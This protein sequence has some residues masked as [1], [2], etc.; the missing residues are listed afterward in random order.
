MNDDM[1]GAVKQGQEVI[2]AIADMIEREARMR[3]LNRW[4]K[5]LAEGIANGV[6]ASTW[7]DGKLWMRDPR[8]NGPYEL[9][10][11]TRK[12]QPAEGETKRSVGPLNRPLEEGGA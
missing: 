11:D 7:Y 6:R 3:D 4:E 2:D 8:L 5:L 9:L 12:D 1:A 10:P